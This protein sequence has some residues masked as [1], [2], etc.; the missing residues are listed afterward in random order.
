VVIGNSELVM[1]NTGM[2]ADLMTR[3][4][5]VHDAALRSAGLV[6]QLLAFARKQTVSPKVLDINKTIASMLKML[7]KLIGE[8]I[9]LIWSPGDNLECVLIDPSQVDQILANLIV[10][11]RDSINGVGTITI[12][13]HPVV[14]DQTYCDNHTWFHPGSFAMLTVSDTGCGMDRNTMDQIFEPFFT[15]K[16]VGHGSGLG[17]ATVYGIIKQNN[18]FIH[19]Y[20]EPGMGTT[21][22]IYLPQAGQKA[23]QIGVVHPETTLSKGS[24][25]I[26]MVE[27]DPAIL[28]VGR[29]ILEQAG[30]T[31]LSTGSPAEA[32]A[33]ARTHDG[34]IDLLI[35]DVVMPKMNGRELEQRIASIR[36]GIRSLFMSGYTANVIAQHGILD[37]GVNFLQK[38]FTVKD[39]IIKVQNTIGPGGDTV[40][41]DATEV[42]LSPHITP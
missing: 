17:L 40:T 15:T 13:T 16:G 11:A 26:L 27:D 4:K 25:T 28:D 41:G 36:P 9:D 39:L 33:I 8:S 30:Y 12:E 14:I 24:G 35:T 38:P 18:G 1:M 5:S 20:S 34:T 3:C 37:E 22:K 10:N 21:F 23:G 42:L 31:V 19:V 29:S 2:D 32:V 6:R 7:Q